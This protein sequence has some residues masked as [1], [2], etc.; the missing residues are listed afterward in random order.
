MFKLSQKTKYALK[1]VFELAGR[2]SAE[3]I[4]AH[5][6]AEA[7]DIPARFLEIIASEL[8]NAGILESR[9]G[10]HGGYVL[11]EKPENITVFD[12]ITAIDGPIEFDDNHGRPAVK[13][14]YSFSRFWQNTADAVISIWKSTTFADL[15]QQEAAAARMLNYCI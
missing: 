2:N 15:L 11:A 7:Q 10:N 13:G 14:D 9:R 3:P 5:A 12:I 6:L 4:S 8:K 1:A